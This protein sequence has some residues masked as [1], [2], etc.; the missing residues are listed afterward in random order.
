MNL[1]LLISLIVILALLI[2]VNIYLLAYF[3]HPDDKGWGATLFCKA[4]VVITKIII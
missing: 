2:I 3:C 1:Y 4:L